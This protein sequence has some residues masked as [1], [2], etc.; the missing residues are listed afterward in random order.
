[1]A[2]KPPVQPPVKPLVNP[3]VKRP[4]SEKE[5]SSCKK[6][7]TVHNQVQP[8]RQVILAVKPYQL[9]PLP[10]LTNTHC[11]SV[12]RPNLKLSQ[13][14]AGLE[15][16]W[17][18]T[19]GTPHTLIS[20]YELYA[21]QQASKPGLAGSWKKV[22]DIKSIPL[23][24]RC[25]LSHFKSGTTYHFVVRAKDLKGQLGEFSEVQKICLK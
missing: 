21:H 19:N 6:Q 22:G 15:V 18:Y 10:L 1:L 14:P 16:Y 8:P 12:P 2:V 5:N 20:A 25:T 17:T 9:P 13:T 3:P 24:I 4:L 23:P 7:A 11:G